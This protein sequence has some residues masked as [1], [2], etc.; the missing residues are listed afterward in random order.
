M[1]LTLHVSPCNFCVGKWGS[2]LVGDSLLQH[3]WWYTNISWGWD[4]CFNWASGE[5]EHWWTKRYDLRWSKTVSLGFL[6]A[7]NNHWGPNKKR[8]TSGNAHHLFHRCAFCTYS[9]SPCLDQKVCLSINMLLTY[10]SCI[11]LSYKNSFLS[12]AISLF[13]MHLFRFSFCLNAAFHSVH[14]LEWKQIH[15]NK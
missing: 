8:N 14:C 2:I 7:K 6:T 5:A 4:W 1:C 13:I 11:K 9:T 15:P 10:F 12:S 3:M